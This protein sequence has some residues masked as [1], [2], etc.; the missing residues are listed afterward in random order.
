MTANYNSAKNQKSRLEEAGLNPALM[1]GQAGSGGAGTGATGGA[2]GQGVGLAQAQGI[3]MALQLKSINAQTKLAEANAAKSYAEA[4]KIAG[5]ESKKTDTE[6][7]GIKQEIEESKN[8][9]KDILAGIPQKEEAYYVQKAQ[10]KLFE[11]ME[12]L[13]KVSGEL[14]EENKR[15][16]TW[17]LTY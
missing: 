17:K 11:S 14:N 7:K 1:Y 8:R 4:N 6:A 2:Q 15:R 16:S 5:V 9:I 12:D 3:G 10:E 13:N